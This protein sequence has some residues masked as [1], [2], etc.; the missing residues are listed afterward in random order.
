M[1]QNIDL[2]DT[3]TAFE[4]KSDK[5]LKR[6]LFI[7]K[8]I[9]KPAIVKVLTKM[10]DLIISSR[11]PIQFLL[12]NT[13]FKVFCAGED[14]EEAGKTIENLKK[15]NVH[16]VL[17]YVAE[18]DN[19]EIGFKKNLETILTNIEFVADKKEG[20]SFVGVK[21]SGLEDVSY[22][23]Q[24]VLNRTDHP[25]ESTD[26]ML[27]FI[28]RVDGICALAVKLNV[29]VYFDAEERSTQDV[30]DFVVEKMMR[31]YNKERVI[32][33][34]TLQMYLNDRIEYL[35]YLLE[36]SI[37][38]NY[39]LG[40]KLVRG[41]YVEKERRK[42]E[43]LGIPSPVYNSKEETD[44][45]YDRA[46]EIC[47]TNHLRICTCLATHNQ[48]SVEKA[49]HLIKE[50][51]VVDHYNKVFFS[52]LFGMSD[53]LTFNLAKAKFNSSK[54]VP[55]GEVKK[56]IPYLLRRAEENT[57]IEGQAGREYDLLLQEKSRRRF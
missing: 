38:N 47:L 53:N 22:L 15:F 43:I 13:V 44:Q 4:Y 2:N 17:D 19:S 55:Y 26:R 25:D 33:Y 36:D 12:K 48:L 16:T 1:E 46:V 37:T 14:R 11:L 54:Y 41:A 8:L 23:E 3:R 31:K 39:L 32:V 51:P 56:A 35:E 28:E 20:N 7:F 45:A 52:Q 18:G 10:A 5:D 50:I 30:F 9:Q 29:K 57:S 49:V 24:L 6:T 40:V 42:A 27:V 21:L 34:N